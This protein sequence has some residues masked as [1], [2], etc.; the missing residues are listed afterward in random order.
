MKNRTCTDFKA[1]MYSSI[2][3]CLY[4]LSQYLR[5]CKG[6][7]EKDN[8]VTNAMSYV[9]AKSLVK[10]KATKGDVK[11]VFALHSSL[12]AAN[13]QRSSNEKLKQMLLETAKSQIYLKCNEG[14]KFIAFLVSLTF[15]II[16]RA[17]KDI[18]HHPI[19]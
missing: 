13:L 9:L 6:L 4:I 19:S 8:I 16:L 2:Y 3:C 11:R 15:C 1:S 5:Y 12:V 10:S 14:I 18:F 17:L 7:P